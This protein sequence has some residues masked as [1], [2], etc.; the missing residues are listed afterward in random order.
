VHG[1]FNFLHFQGL[2]GY[3]AIYWAPPIV[4][5][6]LIVGI[7]L[8]YD[9]FLLVR[10]KEYREMGYSTHEAIVLGYAKTG[11]IITAAG[12]IMA[13]AFSGLLFSDI[14]GMN[15]L[16]FYMVF[17][18]IFDT[19]VVRSLLVPSTMSLLREANWWPG[20]YPK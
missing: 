7:G 5:F 4:S 6:S 16:S 18:V 13:V 9:I 2:Q 11:H 20:M 17:S 1:W 15:M 8:D 3:D 14:P 10:I 19:F 12:V